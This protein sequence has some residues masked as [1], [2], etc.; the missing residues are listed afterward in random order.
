MKTAKEAFFKGKTLGIFMNI[1]EDGSSF[2][3]DLEWEVHCQKAY[4]NVVL[5][6]LENAGLIT[7]REGEDKK[8]RKYVDLTEKGKRIQKSL[9]KVLEAIE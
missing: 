5:D 4:G 7:R 6:K 3:S 9:R 8:T 1:K 2:A